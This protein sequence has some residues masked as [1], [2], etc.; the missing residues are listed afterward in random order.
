VT[1]VGLTAIVH[2]LNNLFKIG[3]IGRNMNAPTVLRFGI[4]AMIGGLAGGLV[5]LKLSHL[6]P[7]ASYTLGTDV[8]FVEPIKVVIGS[9]MLI[10]AV[11]EVAPRFHRLQ[12]GERSLYAGGLLSGFFGGLSGHQGALRS[13]FLIKLGLEKKVFIATGI[14]IAVMVDLARLPTYLSDISQVD[15]RNN[16]WLLTVAVISAFVGAFAGNRLVRK[17][18]IGFIQTLVA[19]LI[20]ILAVLL[21]SGLV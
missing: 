1:A 12:F 9:L 21:I 19:I 3:L 17:V 13:M 18:T 6:R 10:F 7:I 11:L 5:L 4:P 14:A 8:Y 15:Y 20:T 2:L 16:L